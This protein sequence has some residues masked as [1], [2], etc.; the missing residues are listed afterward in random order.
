M[1]VLTQHHD[2]SFGPPTSAA[3]PPNFLK[4]GASGRSLGCRRATTEL[5]QP[6]WAG[7]RLRTGTHQPGLI[8]WSFVPQ[9]GESLE[10]N[11]A[12]GKFFED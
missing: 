5:H 4:V 7:H 11:H 1:Y 3:E 9:W 12:S 2:V 6:R 8:A 10:K